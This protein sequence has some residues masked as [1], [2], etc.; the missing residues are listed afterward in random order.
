MDI[1]DAKVRV[2]NVDSQESGRDIVAQVIGEMSNKGLPHRKFVQTFILA[3]QPNGYYVLNDIFRYIADE[4]EEPVEEQIP[5]ETIETAPPAISAAPKATLQHQESVEVL[6]KK[7]EETAAEP[8]ILPTVIAATQNEPE[9]EATTSDPAEIAN[10]VNN[11]K[12]ATPEQAAQAVDAEEEQAV[13]EKPKDPEP[14]PAPA[15]PV[16]TAAAPV[17]VST[18]E[19]ATSAKATSVPKTWASMLAGSKTAVAVPQIPASTAAQPKA[20]TKSTP[21]PV[22]A[23]EAISAPG[24]ANTVAGLSDDSQVPSSPGGWQTAGQEHNRKQHRQQPSLLGGQPETTSAYIKNVTEKVDAALLK[25]TLGKFGKLA[26]FDV[27]RP[28]VCDM[29]RVTE[30]Y[31]LSAEL[32]FCRIRY[33]SSI[34]S[35]GGS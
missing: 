35:S 20:T 30:S 27:S 8:E 16:K 6:D 23:A 17:A 34:P 1:Q 10:Q 18:P 11:D 3:E 7:L 28:K 31:L 12:P 5:E 19:S 33:S 25:Q 26:Y 15:S 4:D 32:C 24:A 21:T 2:T 9:I 29:D 13:E 22:A 14:T